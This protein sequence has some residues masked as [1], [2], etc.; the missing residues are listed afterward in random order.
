MNFL[1]QPVVDALN[2]LYSKGI[3]IQTCIRIVFLFTD[4]G[5]KT[6]RGKVLNGIFDT[7][8]KVPVMGMKQFNGVCGCPV[9]LHPGKRY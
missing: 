4:L 5:L 7:V 8:A 2:T 1:F 3:S 6:I 9:C